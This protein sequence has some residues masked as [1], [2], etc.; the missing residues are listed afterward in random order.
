MSRDSQRGLVYAAENIVLKMLDRSAL[1]PTVEIHG[2]TIVLEQEHRFG[3]LDAVALYVARVQSMDWYQ[4]RYP[5]VTRLSVRQRRGNKMAH[6]EPDAIAVHD[7]EQAGAAWSLREMVVLHEM[8]HHVS[9]DG[10]GPQFCSE[11]LHHV[12]EVVGEAVAFALQDAMIRN[13]VA[14]GGTR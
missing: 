4:K 12:R 8:A 6:Y 3:S 9:D 2:S 11:L 1:F 5:G 13:N 7:S 14:L 10:H